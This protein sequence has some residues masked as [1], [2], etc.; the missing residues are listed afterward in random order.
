MSE[1]STDHKGN[2]LNPQA[3]GNF[4]V[5][6]FND[7]YLYEVNR[8]TF[9]QLGSDTLF[10]RHFAKRFARED[11]LHVVVGSDSGLLIRF[12]HE[13]GIPPGS[14]F[15]FVEPEPLVAVIEKQLADIDWSEQVRL[16][17]PDKWTELAEE[18]SFQDYAFLGNYHLVQSLGAMDA[19][20]PDYRAIYRDVNAEVEAFTWQVQ[21]RLGNE[22]FVQKQIENLVDNHTPAIHLKDTFRGQTAVL[23][24]GGPSL[25]DMVPWIKA[26]RDNLIVIA[27]SRIARRLLIDDLQPDIVVSIDPHPVSFDVSK[28][29]LRFDPAR[30]LLIHSFHITPLLLAQWPGQAA[31]LGPRF[32]WTT[33][34]NTDNLGAAGP[35]VTNTALGL[36][37]DMGFQRIILGGVDLC[38]TKSGETYASGSN[39]REVGPFLGSVGVQVE[40]NG[41]WMADTRHS[42]A[43]SVS[44]MG[45]QAAAAKELGCTLVNPA[46]GAAKIPHVEHQLIDSIEIDAQEHPPHKVLFNALPENNRE[47]RVH[48]LNTLGKELAHVNGRLRKIKQLA[49][50]GIDCN[51]GL[52]GRNGKTADFKYKKR[53]DKIEKRLDREFKDIS[54][55]V[56]QFGQRVFLRLLRPDRSKEWSDEE[57][58]FWGRAYYE[59][60][61]DS[62]DAL[63]RLVTQQQQLLASRKD[64][65]ADSPAFNKLLEHW[66]QH[67]QP[68]RTN[69]W[70]KQ[71]ASRVGAL[72]EQTRQGFAKLQAEFNAILDKRDTEHLERC[73]GEFSLSTVRSKLSILLLNEEHEELASV[74]Q[75]LEDQTDKSL[76]AYELYYLARGYQAELQDNPEE[77]MLAYQHVT[78]SALQAINEDGEQRPVNPRLEDTLKRMSGIALRANDVDNALLI[79]DS[80]SALAPIFEPQYAELLRLTGNTQAALDVYTDYLH[81]VPLDYAVMLKL[82]R[83]YQD[84]GIEESARWAYS[85]VLEQD[86]D[87]K[88]AGALLEQ[89]GAKS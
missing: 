24:G 72:D 19:Y 28:E 30:V 18:F 84:M 82:G 40:T 67:E 21:F 65:E 54:P 55:L 26:N 31:Y 6:R 58:E 83:I 88:S 38:Y 7:Q 39:E 41:G 22:V 89:L 23:L 85:Y 3:T 35:N 33:K 75:G 14:R 70:R 8:S 49:L 17:P 32:P 87:N 36:A 5:N 29:M 50:D 56:K 4:L 46:P 45:T 51:D 12:I 77:A 81:K 63:L 80:L 73:R 79:L 2:L 20:L 68:G 71:H 66:Q 1:Q 60:Y 15:I 13:R 43:S 69:V 25:D 9:D 53:M 34:R 62:T 64:E 52:W 48:W 37:I 57:I 86:P 47:Y 76:E 11:H 10:Q 42:F 44:I 74:I 27:V 78:D 59:S 16:L 61:R